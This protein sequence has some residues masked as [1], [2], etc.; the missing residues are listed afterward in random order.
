MINLLFDLHRIHETGGL[1][2]VLLQFAINVWN[3]VKSWK[4]SNV[5]V[6][7]KVSKCSFFFLIFTFFEN[8]FLCDIQYIG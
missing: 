4:A 2:E 8:Y 3:H 6:Q 5:Q 7:E 1:E